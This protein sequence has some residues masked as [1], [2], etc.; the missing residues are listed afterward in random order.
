[1]ACHLVGA[2]PSPEPMLKYCYLDHKEQISVIFTWNSNIFIQENTFE[3]IV[4][5]MAAI[6]S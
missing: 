3:S 4:C 5:E 1:M 6:L 2:K